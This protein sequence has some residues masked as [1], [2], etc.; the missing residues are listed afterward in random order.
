M[1]SPPDNPRPDSVATGHLLDRAATGDVSAVGELL[2]RN[3]AALKEFVELH[4]YTSVRGRIDSSDVVQEAQ[5]EMASRLSDF[6]SHRPLPFHLWARKLTYDRLVDLHR[7]HIRRSSRS[8]NR[9]QAQPD[10]SSLLVAKP[11]LAHCPSPSQEAWARELAERV[12]RTLADLPEADREMLLLRHAD[13]LPFAEIG[14]LL[15]IEP[16]AAR[17]RFGRALLRLRTI[18]A[19]AGLLRGGP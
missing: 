7:R 13:G 14:S 8:V 12:S 4:L 19:K 10:R 18:L 6:L 1:S 17:K 9:E 3:R 5:A 16:A 2:T 11:L 15:G